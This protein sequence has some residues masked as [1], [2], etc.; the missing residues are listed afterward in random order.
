VRGAT[1]G[2]DDGA[3]DG[4]EDAEGDVGGAEVG[5]VVH[6]AET[7]NTAVKVKRETR[8]WILKS[9]SLIMAPS[10]PSDL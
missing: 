3:E 8:V 10:I 1:G 5:V 9:G 4:D 7:R 6:A 2:V